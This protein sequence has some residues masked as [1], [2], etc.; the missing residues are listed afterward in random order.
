MVEREFEP[1][2][3]DGVPLVSLTLQ[4]EELIEFRP[5]GHCCPLPTQTRPQLPHL[6]FWCVCVCVCVCVLSHFSRVGLCDFMGS[7]PR[8]SSVRGILQARI[9]G[10][11][12]MPSSRGSSRPRDRTAS[13]MSPALAG[14]FFTTSASWLLALTRN[15]TTFSIFQATGIPQALRSEGSLS[16]GPC[17]FDLTTDFHSDRGDAHLQLAR[18]CGPQTLVLGHLTHSLPLLGRLGLPPRSAISLTVQPGPA[19][20]SSLSLRM[21]P[22]RLQGA[23]EQHA[24]NRSTW[25]LATEPGCPLL[26][27]CIAGQ[28]SAW[29]GAFHQHEA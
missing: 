12:P 7:S 19:R 10:W 8:S 25:T 9:L 5:W 11:V 1:T 15:P 17:E 29:R 4:K 27:V 22:C 24:E 14:G 3:L 28:R 26:E 23:L 18:T 16:W 20:Y 2:S 6:D 21:G 13:L